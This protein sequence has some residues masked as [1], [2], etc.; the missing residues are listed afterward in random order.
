MGSLTPPSGF[1]PAGRV[2]DSP[3]ARSAGRALLGCRSIFETPG[4]RNLRRAGVDR[5]I[6][7]AISMHRTEAVFER[8]NIDTDD[9]LRDA[10]GKRTSYV[11]GLPG[12]PTVV[13]MPVKAGG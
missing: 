12:T 7:M 1:E 13:P 10:V 6:A 4:V 8:Y 2:F 3:R 5:K 9:D 11:N